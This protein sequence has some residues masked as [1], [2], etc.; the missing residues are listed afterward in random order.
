MAK[1]LEMSAMATTSKHICTRVQQLSR[2]IHDS[3][4][5]IV[6][7]CDEIKGSTFRFQAGSFFN[8]TVVTVLVYSCLLKEINTYVP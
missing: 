3:G 6:R 4:R 5:D 7:E 2:V 8:F 1:T